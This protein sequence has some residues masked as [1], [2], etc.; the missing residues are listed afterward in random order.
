MSLLNLRTLQ[1]YVTQHFSRSESVSDIE[2]T[3]LANA[4]RLRS[5]S[6]M[7]FYPQWR[8]IRN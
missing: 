1:I 8:F 6:A 7:T 5:K 2:S 4:E 3:A